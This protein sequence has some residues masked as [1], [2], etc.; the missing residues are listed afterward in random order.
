MLTQ[1]SLLTGGYW[2]CMAPEC[3][4][5]PWLRLFFGEELVPGVGTDSLVTK[6]DGKVNKVLGRKSAFS[7]WTKKEVRT[8]IWL[9]WDRRDELIGLRKF[10]TRSSLCWES[11][12]VISSFL[13]SAEGEGLRVSEIIPLKGAGYL[14]W[15]F[16]SSQA[17]ERGLAWIMEIHIESYILV[18]DS[19]NHSLSHVVTLSSGL[20]KGS[21]SDRLDFIFFHFLCPPWGELHIN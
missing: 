6:S 14:F 12:P 18:V 10:A 3:S 15:R 7:L 8:T 21:S 16:D 2:L 5:F 4:S 13:Q 9:G 1:S 11:K 19:A 17:R 20:F